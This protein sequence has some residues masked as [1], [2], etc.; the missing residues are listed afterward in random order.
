M[1]AIPLRQ[2][3]A[4]TV[5]IG[6]FVDLTDGVTPETALTLGGMDAA[7]II[8]AGATANVDIAG[9]TWAH[10]GN[11]FYALTFATG[12]VDTLGRLTAYFAQAAT[13]RGPLRQDFVV[14]AAHVYD[15]LIAYV[16]QLGVDA[17][18]IYS[19]V[20]AALNLSY[21]ARGI[22]PVTVQSGST[23]TVVTTN[24]I[25][26]T[27]DHYVG[28]SL[29]FV[30]GNLAG[31]AAAISDYDGTSKSLTVSQLTEAPGAGD[32]AIII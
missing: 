4:Q 26:T 7:K 1:F 5:V 32:I 19:N 25:E 29:I 8:K 6:P 9:L 31:Q 10:I 21:A 16:A 14:L 27:D 28:R 2:S 15:S 13:F 11:G 30:T 3:T 23:L 20:A 17:I 12:S 18:A 22:V 24:L